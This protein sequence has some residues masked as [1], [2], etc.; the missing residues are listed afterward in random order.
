[1]NFEDILCK[2]SLSE[3]IKNLSQHTFLKN[4]MGNKDVFGSRNREIPDHDEWIT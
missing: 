1:M 2:V 4:I 3:Q